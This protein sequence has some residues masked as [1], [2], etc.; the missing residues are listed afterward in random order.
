MATKRGESENFVIYDGIKWYKESK[1]YYMGAKSKRLHVYVWEKYNGTV[2]DGYHVH[3][4]DHNKDNNTIENLCAIARNE[5]LS[6]HSLDNT[7]ASAKNLKE[8]AQPEAIKWHKSDAGREWHKEQ[9]KNTIGKSVSVMVAKV[10]EYCGNPYEVS[11][12]CANRSRFCS[13]NC[14]ASFRRKS[15]TDDEERLCACCGKPFSTNKYLSHKYCSLSCASKT[16]LNF[17]KGKSND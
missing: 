17:N 9:W 13:N 4:I 1:G 12:V 2:P 14:K 7:E 5:H 16:T 3:H 8:F 6:R 15:R 11:A 10:C